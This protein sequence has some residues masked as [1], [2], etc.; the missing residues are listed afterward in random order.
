[1]TS[2]PDSGEY[3]IASTCPGAGGGLGGPKPGGGGAFPDGGGTDADNEKYD[4]DLASN[5][6][7]CGGRAPT[8][9]EKTTMEGLLS[10][11]TCSDGRSTLSSM[12]AGGSLKV[13]DTDNGLFGAWNSNTQ[14][15]YI[16]RPKHWDA[17]T[18]AVNGPELVDTL[19]QE[20]VH[21]LLGHVN[22]PQRHDQEWKDKMAAC[23][24]PQP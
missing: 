18:G 8:D 15:I 20:V 24:F 19:V 22:G 4:E 21:K 2:S 3:T 23:G 5:C 14:T 6:P 17:T 16:S 13:Y 9:A 7:G 1:M 10:Q 12:I 11:V